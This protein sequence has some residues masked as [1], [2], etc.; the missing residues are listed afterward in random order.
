[1][2]AKALAIACCTAFLLGQ[3]ATLR[4]AR[5]DSPPERDESVLFGDIPTVYSASKYEQTTTAAPSSVS[6]VTANDIRNYGYR[7]LAEILA[8]VRGFYVTYDR[9]YSYLGVRGFGRPGDYNSRVLL[10]VDGH[11]IN[12][13]IYSQGLLGTEFPLDVDLIDRVEVIR[14]PGSSI[15]GSNAFFAVV[16]V[17]TKQ[18]RD[19]KG[20]EVSVAAGN[21]LTTKERASFGKRFENGLD[22]L[23]SA[24]GYKSAGVRDLFFP[25]F[26]SP[27]NNNGVAVDHDADR[28]KTLLTNLSFGDFNLRLLDGSRRKDVPTASFGTLF[29][30]NEYTTD[31]RQYFDLKYQRQIDAVS[32]VTARVYQD[33]YGYYGYYPIG[34]SPTVVNYDAIDGRW[35]G[36]EYQYTRRIGAEHRATVGA[37]YVND[38][39]QT[40]VNFNLDPYI[41]L[42]D[43]RARSS[44]WAAF[45]QDEY[46]ITPEL[47]LTAGLRYDSLT[48][49][50]SVET[51]TNPRLAL[52]YAPDADTALKLLF[53][54]AF[55]APNAYESYYASAAVGFDPSKNLVPEKIKTTELVL[56][57][58][59]TDSV[60]GTVDIYRNDIHQLINLLTN[61]DGT[62]FFENTDQVRAV[63]L[64]LELDG[65]WASG[66]ESRTSYTLQHTTDALTGQTL[67]NSPQNIAKSNL[68]APL[69]ADDLSSGIEVQYVGSRLTTDNA[70]LGGFT[71][72]NLTL[73]E[74]RLRSGVEISG[75][76]Y[77]VFAKTYADPVSV[78][79]QETSIVQDGRTFLVRLT[80]PF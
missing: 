56:D 14:G 17:I 12:D 64:E 65:R 80:F 43:S 63:G 38:Y 46:A 44:A 5:A 9:N 28:S 3:A 7:T 15:Y 11:R 42:L 37:E 47:S 78:G 59:L 53:G 1:M 32:E 2:Q 62:V 8:S 36:T 49:L 23:V 30:G 72:V 57:R 41:S 39:R 69:L 77:N 18:A 33:F 19:L 27:G 34:R 79:N 60:R 54:T 13:D 51:S 25:D 45:V 70:R 26:D 61:P 35:W 40:Q 66:L 22:L 24:T 50:A 31:T 68:R 76:V 74:R 75:S 21:E 29:N 71:V 52:I 16:N 55:R 48:S 67:T 73:F 58:N 10:L 6:I 20:G 4:D